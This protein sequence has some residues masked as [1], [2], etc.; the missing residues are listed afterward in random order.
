LC[1]SSG[2]AALHR[3]ATS[4]ERRV[5]EDV[6]ARGEQ[7]LGDA[8]DLRGGLALTEDDLGQPLPERAVVVDAREAEILEGEVRELP[9]G[10][11]GTHGARAHPLEELRRRVQG[12]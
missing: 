5:D 11:S 8:D 9:E 7:P 12:S 6:L 2:T 3:G 10:R 4:G 1:S